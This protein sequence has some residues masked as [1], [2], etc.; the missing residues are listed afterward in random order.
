MTGFPSVDITSI[1]AGGGSIAW[2]DEGGLLRI[3]PESAGADPGPAC[4]V[5]GGMRPTVTDACV[6]LGYIDP[7]YFLGGKMQLDEASARHAIERD[8]G[9]PLGLDM[10]AAAYAIVEL[11]TE[12][13]VHAIE[14]VTVNH[15]VD[16]ASAVLV[17]GGGAA[18]L[19]SVK[20]ASRLGMRRVLF[21][22]TGAVLSAAGALLADLTAN[23]SAPAVTS[24]LNFD[25]MAV[26][27]RL[28]ALREQCVKFAAGPGAGASSTSVVC[29]VEARYERQVWELEI[30]LPVERFRDAADV[31]LLVQKFHREHES[32]FAVADHGAGIE[33]LNWNARVSCR[34]HSDCP[35]QAAE[36]SRSPNRPI[37]QRMV[38]FGTGQRHRTPVRNIQGLRV[39]ERLP[40][41]AI[42]ES[43]YTTVVIEPM[44]AAE[45]LAGGGLLVTIDDAALR[46]GSGEARGRSH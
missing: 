8:V 45:A 39:G 43:G 23:F 15:G 19:N 5:R 14:N 1:G 24:S 28:A 41:P 3:G 37:K 22:Q 17:A 6:V 42:I 13:M 31:E 16:P 9:G 18:G 7:A 2:V 21:P 44:S 38:G 46:P 32:V 10:D 33:M 30:E 29:S 12:K 35:P 4:Y 34:L 36:T 26:H 40:G 27:T 25:F 11:A 20:I